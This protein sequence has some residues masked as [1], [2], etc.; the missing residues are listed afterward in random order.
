MLVGWSELRGLDPVIG[1]QLGKLGIPLA[2]AAENPLGRAV[3]ERRPIGAG[4]GRV[5]DIA[6]QVVAEPKPSR[7][8]REALL[9]ERLLGERGERIP[10]GATE[11]VVEGLL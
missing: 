9:Q 1:D 4:K 11:Q 2:G 5:R 7:P 10:R 8:D 3:V 6:D